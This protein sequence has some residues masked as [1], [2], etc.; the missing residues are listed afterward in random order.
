MNMQACAVRGAKVGLVAG[1][2]MNAVEGEVVGGGGG[3]GIGAGGG[4]VV[5]T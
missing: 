3:G 2:G 4:S 5:T 1:L